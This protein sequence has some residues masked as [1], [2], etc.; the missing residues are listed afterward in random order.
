MRKGPPLR[1]RLNSRNSLIFG[2]VFFAELFLTGSFIIRKV[3]FRRLSMASE[4][5]E[6]LERDFVFWLVLSILLNVLVLP[7]TLTSTS[8]SSSLYSSVMGDVFVSRNGVSKG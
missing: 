1:L 5:L 8:R 3:S 4:A 7:W 6:T 2:R